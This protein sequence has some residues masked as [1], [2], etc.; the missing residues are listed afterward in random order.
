MNLNKGTE[1]KSGPTIDKIIACTMTGYCWVVEK[2]T[3][4]GDVQ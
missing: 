1:I 3:T 4:V 2:V